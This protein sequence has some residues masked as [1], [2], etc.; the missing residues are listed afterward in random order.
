MSYSHH[1]NIQYSSF[2]SFDSNPLYS[3]NLSNITTVSSGPDAFN[4][5]LCYF[6]PFSLSST[7]HYFHCI[8]LKQMVLISF[9][10]RSNQGKEAGS[11]ISYKHSDISRTLLFYSFKNT[12]PLRHV[13]FKSSVLMSTTLLLPHLM[14][15][16]NHCSAYI[17][18][19]ITSLQLLVC[20][21]PQLHVHPLLLLV[22][23]LFQIHPHVICCILNWIKIFTVTKVKILMLPLIL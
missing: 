6:L 13:T 4:N 18:V 9:P 5:Q 20:T 10:P 15:S 17:P 1:H 14:K 22:T 21:N 11:A 7:E 16:M 8:C 12:I 2:F 19:P 3:L 23:H